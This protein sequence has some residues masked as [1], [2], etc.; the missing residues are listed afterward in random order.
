MHILLLLAACSTKVSWA[1]LIDSLLCPY[2]LLSTC[3]LNYWNRSVEISNH[4]LFT[5]QFFL[6]FFFKNYFILFYFFETESRPVTQAEVQWHN[7]GSL[8]P[9]PPGFK[10]FSCL[11]LLS[12]W[13]YRHVPPYPANICIFSRNGVLTCWPGLSWFLD[14]MIRLTWPPKVLGLQAWATM[15]G[16][17]IFK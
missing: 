3:S 5:C 11:S 9:Q 16:D 13:D 8:Q 2:A 6:N 12:S 14:L 4:K 10:L 7:L 15:P 1:N 17:L